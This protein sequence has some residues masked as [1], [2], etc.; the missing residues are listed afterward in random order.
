MLAGVARET[1][2]LQ[3]ERHDRAHVLLFVLAALQGRLFMQSAIERHLRIEGNEFGELIDKTV[4]EAQHATDVAHH[5]LGRHRAV[6]NDL[7][8]LIAPIARRDVFD[9]LVAP[10]HAKVD[11]EVGHRHALGIQ[12]ALEQQIVFERIEFR[13]AEAESRQRAGARAAPWTYR[14]FVLLGP[15]D[16]VGDDQEIA[17]KTHRDDD[18]ELG[19][20]TLAIGLD[21]RAVS[22]RYADRATR[23]ASL[24]SKRGLLAQQGID[25]HALA[26]RIF[27]QMVSAELE[28][29]IAAHRNVDGVG[30][31]CGQV[32]EQFAHFI[33]AA[34]K[35]LRRIVALAT[36][37]GDGAAVMNTHP[38]LMGIEFIGIDE[39]H[40]IGRDQ[41]HI[42]PRRA[43]QHCVVVTFLALAAGAHQFDVVAIAEQ[44]APVVETLFDLI[45]LAFEGQ[46]PDIAS[47]AA[48]QHQQPAH[49]VAMQPALL[50]AGDPAVLAKA[51]GHGQQLTE[52]TIARAVLA[53]QHHAKTLGHT[54]RRRNPDFDSD[55]GLDAGFLCGAIKLGQCKDIVLVGQR[56]GRHAEFAAAIGER[57]DTHDAVHDRIFTVDVK[58]NKARRGHARSPA[59]NTW[60]TG[61]K[62]VRCTTLAPQRCR[63]ATWA[64]VG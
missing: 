15:F 38:R 40:I 19:L 1:F 31:R 11:V 54:G 32:G 3:R 37:I 10:V 57:I 35:L 59:A 36:R 22:A 27:R 53:Q 50:D 63:A 8:D 7:R 24:E 49:R 60:R 64:A 62:E 17:G 29:E 23:E 47:R 51:I 33:F 52:I 56:D 2:Q 55:D 4:R 6:G 41:G 43:F 44:S 9:D 30:Q 13:N 21:L 20:E 5:G 46:A 12:K 58:M 26:D 25:V 48:R 45:K 28:F 42:E 34:Q 18:F 61:A 14:D 16:E 39:A